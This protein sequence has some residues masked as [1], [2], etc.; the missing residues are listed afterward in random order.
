MKPHHFNCHV[1]LQGVQSKSLHLRLYNTSI[2]SIPEKAFQQLGRVENI[3]I[4]VSS[5]NKA[6]NKQPNPNTAQRPLE[7]ER[8]YLTDLKIAGNSLSCDCD[9]G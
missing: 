9:I 5:N 7:S 3:S 8:V 4:D 6:L 1:N 2:A